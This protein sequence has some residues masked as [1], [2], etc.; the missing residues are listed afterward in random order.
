MGAPWDCSSGRKRQSRVRPGRRCAYGF[1][2]RRRRSIDGGSWKWLVVV[3]EG[4]A[5]AWNGNSKM[6]QSRRRTLC[7]W[8]PQWPIQRRG[9]ARQANAEVRAT[10]DVQTTVGSLELTAQGSPRRTRSRATLPPRT[11]LV[12]YEQCRQGSFSDEA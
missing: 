5:K 6:R 2:R 10:A 11:A 4:G 3:G 7:I 12:I 1:A 8:L 9:V